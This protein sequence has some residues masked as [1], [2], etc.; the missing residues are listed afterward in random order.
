MSLLC[1]NENTEMQQVKT[2]SHYG[3]TVTLDQCPGCGGIWFDSA[4]LYMPKQGEAEKIEQ[5]NFPSLLSS[6]NIQSQ[7]LLCPRDRTPLVQFSDPFFPQ[8]LVLAR[9]QT[10]NGFWL[11]RGEFVK[12]QQFRQ[13]R[14]TPRKPDEIVIDDTE[15][16]QELLKILRANQ[17]KDSVEVLGKLGKF[18]STPMDSLTWQPLQPEK[19]SDKE[20]GAVNLILTAL[21][22]ILRFF[23]RI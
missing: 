4:E 1:P 6:A 18:L 10:C 16:G 21:S 3:Q 12:Y 2:E 15:C 17:S 11:N 13:A 9:C 7:S 14:Q 20:K 5:L 8:D 22:L 23:V 19:L